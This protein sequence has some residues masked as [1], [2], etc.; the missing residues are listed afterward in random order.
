MQK[1][2]ERE[3]LLAPS[4]AVGEQLNE[5]RGLFTGDRRLCYVLGKTGPNAYQTGLM[6]IR[7]NSIRL[8]ARGDSGYA[9]RV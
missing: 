9:G 2:R 4:R 3:V 6:R 1:M 8:A 5:R 7:P